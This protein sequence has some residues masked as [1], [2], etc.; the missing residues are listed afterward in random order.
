MSIYKLECFILFYRGTM[1]VRIPT[2]ETIF[3][4]PFI[5]IKAYWIT[6]ANGRVEIQEWL[7]KKT[8]FGYFLFDIFVVKYNLELVH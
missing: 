6:P 8:R 3:H 1:W 5:L 7:T 2:V 4:E